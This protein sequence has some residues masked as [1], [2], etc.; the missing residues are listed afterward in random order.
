MEKK[1]GHFFSLLA[2]G[3]NSWHY[4]I[5]GARSLP[6]PN[7]VNPCIWSD[8]I[9]PILGLALLPLILSFFLNFFYRLLNTG[10]FG[11][12]YCVVYLDD[13]SNV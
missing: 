2:K 1:N 10:G 12:P 11:V 3:E 7:I 8:G 13:G 6:Y 4:H 5:I 9:E